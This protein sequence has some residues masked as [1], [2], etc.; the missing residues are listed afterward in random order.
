MDNR[1]AVS[2]LT[3]LVAARFAQV[4]EE[5]L[6]DAF[7]DTD[8]AAL[9]PDQLVTAVGNRVEEVVTIEWDVGQPAIT[10]DRLTLARIIHETIKD[11]T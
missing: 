1:D 3:D 2:A 4:F 9:D 5:V 7:A 10:V 6:H 8:L 11:M